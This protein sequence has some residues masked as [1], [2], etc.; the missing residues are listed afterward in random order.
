MKWAWRLALLV[1]G[2]PVLWLAAAL[3]L[4]A[5]RTGGAQY[6]PDGI[7]IHVVSNGYHA[8]FVLPVA[9]AGLDWRDTFG[10]EQFKVDIN[11]FP[12]VAF[13]WGDREVYMN[14]PRIEDLKLGD[15][16]RAL[17]LLNTTVTRVQYT[18]PLLESEHSR[19]LLISPQRYRTL[20]AYVRA[21]FIND[22]AGRPILIGHGFADS[23][24]FYE[25]VGRYSFIYTCNE[26]V[27]QGLRRISAPTGLWT[28]LAYQVLAHL[29]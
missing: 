21:A 22:S 15:G 24:G 9:A 5:I 11:G 25:G 28:P 8:S 2:L 7:P 10:P 6:D 19:R 17:F 14:T 26:W 23:D 12:Y 13:G 29:E 18:F 3:G 20:A 16:A 1:P 4:G 27:G